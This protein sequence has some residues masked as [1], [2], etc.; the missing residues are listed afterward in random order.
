MSRAADYVVQITEA[1]KTRPPDFVDPRAGSS[2]PGP[3]LKLRLNDEG[4]CA[5]WLSDR[6]LPV[7][8]LPAEVLL[9]VEEWIRATFR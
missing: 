2:E 8:V 1:V 9:A 4:A 5:V 7:V 3:Y 6:N